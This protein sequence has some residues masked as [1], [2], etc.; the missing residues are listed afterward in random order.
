MIRAESKNTKSRKNPLGLTEAR[1]TH[2]LN[3]PNKSVFSNS[4]TSTKLKGYVYQASCSQL[5]KI[6][7]NLSKLYKNLELSD[8]SDS[9][10]QREEDSFGL[11][12]VQI[13]PLYFGKRFSQEVAKY[14][15][16][17][18]SKD[19]AQLPSVGEYRRRFSMVI[20]NPNK[21]PLQ[22]ISEET[23]LDRLGKIRKQNR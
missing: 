7:D 23:E 4:P 12:M 6:E 21:I 17:E 9:D 16:R 3:S 8:F 10:L 2:G 22:M 19:K 5:E 18:E 20:N 14:E 1:N 13:Q 15:P 11:D